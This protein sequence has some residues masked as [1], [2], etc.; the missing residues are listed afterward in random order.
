MNQV[1][2]VIQD[3]TDPALGL[4]V[5]GAS[6]T[7]LPGTLSGSVVSASDGLRFPEGHAS[8]D[9]GDG[10]SDDKAHHR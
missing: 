1:A 2:V 6:E 9:R 3:L 10:R 8:D 7:G 4:E 5:S